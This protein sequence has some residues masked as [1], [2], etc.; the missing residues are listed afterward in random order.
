M[1]RLNQEIHVS[2]N[3]Q[4]FLSEQGNLITTKLDEFIV[5]CGYGV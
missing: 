4:F 1:Y 3:I 2:T 5:G